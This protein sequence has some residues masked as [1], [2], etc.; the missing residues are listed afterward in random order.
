MKDVFVAGGTGY[1]GRRLSEEL[2]RRGHSVSVLVRPGSEKRIAAGCRPVPGNAL[3]RNTFKDDLAG[4]HTYVQLVGVAHPSPTKRREFR[5]IDLKSCQESLAAAVANTVHH[6]VYVS[7]A[8]PAPVMKAYVEVR[9]ECERLIRE[10]WLSATILRPW[11]VLGPGHYWPYLLKPFYWMARKIPA[12]TVSAERLGLVTL[13]QMVRA[14]VTA[15]ESPAG[16]VRVVE[17]PEIV[18][19]LPRDL[20]A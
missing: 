17:V 7:V 5:R 9:K 13:P 14:L 20:N 16:A 6:F 1:M 15:V 18:R 2:V 12:S 19:L 10:S 11:Y 8:H 3:D 4:T